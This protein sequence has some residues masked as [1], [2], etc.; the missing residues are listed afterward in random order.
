MQE[1]RDS[2]CGQPQGAAQSGD[3]G[4]EKRS[5]AW[6]GRKSIDPKQATSGSL[7]K[8]FSCKLRLKGFLKKPA[9]VV[10]FLDYG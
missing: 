2:R 4:V 3:R 9:K 8:T 5:W 6:E 10:S 1:F 7:S